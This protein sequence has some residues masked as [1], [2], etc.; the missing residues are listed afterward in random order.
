MQPQSGCCKAKVFL[1]RSRAVQ[2]LYRVNANDPPYLKTTGAKD[3]LIRPNTGKASTVSRD[4]D[5]A[6][7]IGVEDELKTE[8]P[9]PEAPGM[10]FPRGPGSMTR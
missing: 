9:S 8:G 1:R 2:H 6:V 7:E 5:T 4:R 3:D 10:A